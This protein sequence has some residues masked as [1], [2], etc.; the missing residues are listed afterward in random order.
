MPPTEDDLAEAVREFFRAQD[1]AVRAALQSVDVS[2]AISEMA[3]TPA[4]DS[5]LEQTDVWLAAILIEYLPAWYAAGWQEAADQL[6]SEIEMLMRDEADARRRAREIVPV[7]QTTTRNALRDE[8]ENAGE[9]SADRDEAMGFLLYGVA[10]RYEGW[11]EHRS[12]LVAV[13]ESQS[14]IGRGGNALAK[15]VAISQIVQKHNIDRADDRVCGNCLANT[16]EGWIPIGQ[17]F[18]ASETLIKPHHPR[19]RC[20]MDYR[21]GN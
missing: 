15:L 5:A 8:A 14:A 12:E 10:S 20:R 18:A 21:S 16:A 11:Q 6:A 7:I 4:V 17:L 3:D 9:M 19:C 2:Y 1:E 13:T